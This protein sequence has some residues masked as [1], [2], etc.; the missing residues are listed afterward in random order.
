VTAAKIDLK[1]GETLD[2]IGHYMTYG[3]AENYPLARQQNL[4]PIGVAEGCVLRR[5]V[6]KDQVLTYDDVVL[7]EGRLID[8]LRREQ[9][10]YFGRPAAAPALVLDDTLAP[11]AP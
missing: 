4:L 6:P 10:A 3:L 5:A 7:P 1:A 2:G 9:E 8:Q 11:S